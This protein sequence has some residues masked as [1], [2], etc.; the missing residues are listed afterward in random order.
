MQNVVP[1]CL[2]ST[3]DTMMCKTGED[4]TITH[5]AVVVL[6]RCLAFFFDV[7]DAENHTEPQTTL[8]DVGCRYVDMED[9]A[10]LC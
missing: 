6:A 5:F 10:G 7:V 8:M 1:F 9:V 3:I 4:E 2:P